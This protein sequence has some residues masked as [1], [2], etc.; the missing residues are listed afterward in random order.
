VALTNN[1]CAYED[2]FE[3]YEQ[4][5]NSVKGIRVL[6][7]TKA[8]ASM[9]RMRLNHARVLERNEAKKLYPPD[10]PRWGKSEN[11]HLRVMLKPAA[12]DDGKFWVYIEPWSI[13]HEHLGVEEIE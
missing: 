1:L 7:A 10:D 11:D 13:G 5:R 12:E 2:C 9:F 6:H 3:H 4:A 8:A